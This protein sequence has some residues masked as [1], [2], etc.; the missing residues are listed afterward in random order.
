M[1][2]CIFTNVICLAEDSPTQKDNLRLTY[3]EFCSKI[4]ACNALMESKEPFSIKD[5]M[6]IVRV[7]NTLYMYQYEDFGNDTQSFW[8]LAVPA[9]SRV[10]QALGKQTTTH[11]M[12]MYFEKFDLY[13]GGAPDNIRPYDTYEI[14]RNGRVVKP[15]ST[16]VRLVDQVVTLTDDQKDK[17]AQVYQQEDETLK[18]IPQESR[19]EKGAPIRDAARA[20]IRALLTPEQQQKFDANP[21]GAEDL[22]ERKYVT[23]FLKS[24]QFIAARVGV[25]KTVSPGGLPSIVMSNLQDRS[26]QGTYGYEVVGNMH[27]ETF[28][29]DWARPSPTAPIKIIRIKG[30][31]GETIQP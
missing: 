17:V 25:V 9:T 24:S 19:A 15:E 20:Q 1:F 4:H 8:K 29:I 12:G 27:T 23:S 30:S 7:Y 10:V 13:W 16:A 26:L 14:E 18:A 21:T 31:D 2:F 6:M 3:P 22:E 11:G 28:K 5:A